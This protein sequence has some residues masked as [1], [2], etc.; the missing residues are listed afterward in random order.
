MQFSKNSLEKSIQTSQCFIILRYKC[1]YGLTIIGTSFIIR[2][3]RKELNK[4][5]WT[6]KDYDTYSQSK[7]YVD[8]AIVP[9]I[10]ISMGSD[11]KTLISKGE[12]LHLISHEVERQLKG[13]V[14]LLPD[15]SY[16]H[17]QKETT[18]KHIEDVKRELH[19]EFKHVMFL[20]C[21]DTLKH[22]EF[23]LSKDNLIY[24]PPVPFEHMDDQLKRKLLQDQVEQI[25]NILLQSWNKS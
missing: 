22:S 23:V 9:L 12:F 2:V 1:Y 17:H 15:F 16:L 19:N 4:M 25:L 20:T 14:Y 3:L 13:R 21:D 8:T 10:P 5:K 7:D 18:M 6:V 24:L 11:A